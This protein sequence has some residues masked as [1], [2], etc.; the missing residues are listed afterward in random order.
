MK[1]QLPLSRVKTQPVRSWLVLYL[2]V[3][4]NS[5]CA[6]LCGSAILKKQTSQVYCGKSFLHTALQKSF[7]MQSHL[8]S[9][10]WVTATQ[11]FHQWP[12]PNWHS[13]LNVNLI[14]A[15]SCTTVCFA[16]AAA[17]VFTGRRLCGERFEVAGHV[18][19]E[20]AG[21]ENLL[22]DLRS[23]YRKTLVTAQHQRNAA[24]RVEEK[25]VDHL[26]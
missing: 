15:V 13:W 14:V 19:L 16:G 25:I 23:R 21:L 7:H 2:L 17:V 5:V 4:S 1:Q 20:R 24:R 10:C 3:L 12:W 26:H 11:T 8:I 9:D 18:V 22:A 6:S